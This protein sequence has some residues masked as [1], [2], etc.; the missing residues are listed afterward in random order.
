[1]NEHTEEFEDTKGATK[2]RKSMDRQHNGQQMDRQHNGQ[3]MNR[4]HNGQQMDKQHNG[5]QMDRQHNGQQKKD[6]RTNNDLQNIH[7]KLKIE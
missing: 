2:I 6:E 7:I 4:Q 1:M 5:Q 3:Q